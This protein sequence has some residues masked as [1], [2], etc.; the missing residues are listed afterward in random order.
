M[1]WSVV[2]YTGEAF[3]IERHGQ[4]ACM[5]SEDE[6]DWDHLID[7]MH[8]L[9]HTDAGIDAIVCEDY[10]IYEHKLTRHTFSP[11]YTLRI[12]GAIELMA[13]YYHLPVNFQMAMQAKGFVSDDKLKAW[14]FWQEGMRHSR[15][16]IR[17]VL[18]WLLFCK[19]RKCRGLA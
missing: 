5:K 14:D 12:I 17:H 18:Y 15:D 1:G 8:Q 13:A 6:V 11:V 10:R 19:E 2:R 9:F 7:F 3:I 16:S 4:V